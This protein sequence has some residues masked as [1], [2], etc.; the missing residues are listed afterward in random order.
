MRYYQQPIACLVVKRHIIVIWWTRATLLWRGLWNWPPNEWFA[1]R[2]LIEKLKKPHFPGFLESFPLRNLNS[3]RR[4]GY[5]RGHCGSE[6]LQPA[7]QF[8]IADRRIKLQE[9]QLPL[10]AAQHCSVL[11][12]PLQKLLRWTFRIL[13]YDMK[14]LF[15][16]LLKPQR[17][18][19][20][21]RNSK[22]IE[23]VE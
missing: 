3:G 8:K 17:V 20:G 2:R 6:T 10:S 18:I 15:T 23:K 16:C 5:S 1:L 13:C 9:T 14:L 11:I 21:Q 12:F 19:N 4:K 22:K 7:H